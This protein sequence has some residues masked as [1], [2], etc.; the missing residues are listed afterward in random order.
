MSKNSKDLSRAKAIG[1][2][3]ANLRIEKNLS[4]A[5][6]AERLNVGYEAI[7]RIERGTVVPTISKLID[8]AEVLDCPVEAL[9]IKSS[10]RVMDQ[11]V[12]LSAML[13][14]LPEVDRRFMLEIIEQMAAK[15]KE[16]NAHGKKTEIEAVND[17][18]DVRQ[19]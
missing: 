6:V 18:P 10:N 12:S 4:Q 9:L 13:E 17:A 16:K 8:L 2:I 15:L 11:G 5:D 14:G 1:K 7:S 3:I 19:R